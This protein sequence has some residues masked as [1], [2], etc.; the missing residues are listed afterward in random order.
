MAW[1]YD[2]VVLTEKAEWFD[3]SSTTYIE[4][5]IEDLLSPL[6]RETLAAVN[7]TVANTSTLVDSEGLEGELRGAKLNFNCIELSHC[8]KRDM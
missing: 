7:V 5:V 1:A 8:V 3:F 6:P 4:C 2:S